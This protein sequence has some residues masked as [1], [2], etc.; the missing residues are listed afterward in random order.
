MEKV[1]WQV[2][3]ATAALL[4]GHVASERPPVSQKALF[5]FVDKRFLNLYRGLEQIAQRIEAG[6][7]EAPNQSVR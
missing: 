3:Q 6:E 2:F 7:D 1:N 4:A 5:E